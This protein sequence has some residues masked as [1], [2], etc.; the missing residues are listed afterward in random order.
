M[1]AKKMNFALSLAFLISP[2]SYAKSVPFTVL[3]QLEEPDR[4]EQK[5]IQDLLEI[6]K[7]TMLDDAQTS[8]AE[9]R[10]V[11]GHSNKMLRDAHPKSPG[12][13]KAHFSI[14][15]RD[16]LRELHLPKEFFSR[17]LLSE[18]HAGKSYEAVVRFS[19]AANKNGDDKDARG[20]AIK[21]L[22]IDG[23]KWELPG[24]EQELGS[25]RNHYTPKSFHESQDFVMIDNP[26]L[27]APDLKAF[28]GLLLLVLGKNYSSITHLGELIAALKFMGKPA[29]NLLS[30]D[31]YSITPYAWFG[32]PMKFNAHPHLATER[33]ASSNKDPNILRHMIERTLHHQDVIFDFRI[34]TRSPDEYGIKS[35]IENA[36]TLWD[37]Q[38]YP[39]KTIAK[40]T[41]PKGQTLSSEGLLRDCDDLSFNIWNS[42]ADYQP[43]GSINRARRVL[44]KLLSDY[45]HTYNQHEGGK[46]L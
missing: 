13:V 24:S 1:L 46:K 19:N 36:S 29:T 37:E 42:L 8:N 30:L 41:I 31:F 28:K 7:E 17:G 10:K 15:S 4:N 5:E 20:M 22:G 26:T 12:C 9:T 38:D 16:E 3:G 32:V 45:R 2:S 6:L 44:Y 18:E 27:P 11:L 25:P 14:R 43:V 21:I 34:Q 33:V 40:L 35:V 23:D 39:F